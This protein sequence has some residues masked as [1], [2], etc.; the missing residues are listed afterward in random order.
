VVAAVSNAAAGWGF[1]LVVDPV[2]YS[3]HGIPLLPADALFAVRS[4][5]LPRAALITPN[6]PEAAALTG[7]NDMR[8]S[9]RGLYEMGA[10][11][12]LIKGGHRGGCAIDLL[13]DGVKF[14]ELPAE[15]I[16]TR[17]THGTGCTLSA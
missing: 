3:K 5:L 7:S 17:H 2:M 6:I 8:E 15:R 16:E 4:K 12:A 11:A 14:L 10:R 13:F 9:A 1:P